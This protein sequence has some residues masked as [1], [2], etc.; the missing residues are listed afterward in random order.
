MIRASG[1]DDRKMMNEVMVKQL[2]DWFLY[3]KE[4]HNIVANGR[5][6][7]TGRLSNVI[8]ANE[9]APPN[10]THTASANA[11]ADAPKK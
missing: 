6:E 5:S 9:Y 2:T 11:C 10:L 3:V 1:I 4:V 8:F 7:R